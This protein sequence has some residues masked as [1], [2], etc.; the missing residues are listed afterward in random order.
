LIEFR[1]PVD[2]VL[3]EIN[4][5]VFE[6]RPRPVTDSPAASWIYRIKPADTSALASTML[7]GRSAREWIEHEIERLKVFL[8]TI[9]PRHPA[10]GE[11][12]QDGGAPVAGVTEYLDDAGRDKLRERFFG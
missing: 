4:H 1:A 9:V 7:L 10:L 11:T 12:M 5:D 2:G 3:E 8:A 6:S